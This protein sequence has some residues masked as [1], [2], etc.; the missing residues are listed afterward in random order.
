MNTD[1]PIPQGNAVLNDHESWP[2]WFLQLKYHADRKIIWD[3]VNPDAP[4]VPNILL[5]E[6]Q[7]P[8]LSTL[9]PAPAP[10]P[11]P[12]EPTASRTTRSSNTSSSQA[13]DP[14][15]APPPAQTPFQTALEQYTIQKES[16]KIEWSKWSTKAKRLQHLEDW[17]HATVTKELLVPA[18]MSLQEQGETTLQALVKALKS[19]LAPSEANTAA[20][21][22]TQY[23]A[24]LEKAKHG[25][26]DPE[27][28]QRE[29]NN[30]HMKA[31][32][33]KIPEVSGLLAV[34]D[35]LDALAHKVAPDWARSTHREILAKQARDEKIDTLKDVGKIFS[36]LLQEQ[37]VRSIGNNPGIFVTLREGSN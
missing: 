21:V 7:P 30:L 27:L 31:K 18:M 8:T 35:Y 5:E 17:V 34:Q 29:W 2:Y 1:D 11:P 36:L 24:H 33:Y 20:L 6:P 19:Q 16:Y 37:R 25:T 4:E 14:P 28:W 26:M 22:R 9:A 15:A 32:A 23:R 3:L 10:A 13:Q 12:A